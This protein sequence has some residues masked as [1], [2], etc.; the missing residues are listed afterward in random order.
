[1]QI[2]RE[3]LKHVRLVSQSWSHA[4]A[5]L[6]WHAFSTDL[7]NTSTR[8]FDALLTSQPGG[9]L[10]SVRNLHIRTANPLSS[11][12]EERLILLL[13]LLPRGSLQ[14]FTVDH[15]IDSCTLGVLIIRQPHLHI[16][17][18]PIK[19]DNVPPSGS[20]VAGNLSR[21]EVLTVFANENQKGYDAWFPYSPN[22]QSLT[23][24]G[25][26]AGPTSE[27]EPWGSE[28]KLKKLSSLYLDN[29]CFWSS[30]GALDAWL[31]L[32]RLEN[33]TVRN[34]AGSEVFLNSLAEAYTAHG[35][36]ALR[37]FKIYSD[38][39]DEELMDELE[40]F[41][42]AVRGLQ[43]LY[44]SVTT[45]QR[46]D[47]L[48]ICNQA[49]SLRYLVV[50]YMNSWDQEE[51][52]VDCIYDATELQCL[53]KTCSQIEELGLS[54]AQINFSEWPLFEPFVWSPVAMQSSKEKQIIKFLVSY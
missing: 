13:S 33:L 45:D 34:C 38:S 18:S 54:C 20:F 1:M 8:Q 44:V 5:A 4:A 23:V 37:S 7:S 12:T 52:G 41:L 15:A 17:S 16:L 3:S 14:K 50:E 6:L 40:T 27:F 9:F 21:L 31:D 32:N 47:P 19:R 28:S 10:D 11:Q 48:S 51:E 35:L 30:A 25:I 36:S 46:L 22:L 49:S 39:I 42:A 2:P 26:F 29:L 43:C 53:S 24:S